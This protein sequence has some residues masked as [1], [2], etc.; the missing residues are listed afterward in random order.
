MW[1]KRE[2]NDK[3]KGQERIKKRPGEKNKIERRGVKLF[4]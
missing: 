1:E 3:V 4:W 2:R